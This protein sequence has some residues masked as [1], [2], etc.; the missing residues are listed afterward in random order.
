MPYDSPEKNRA[1]MAAALREKA[2]P[3]EAEE[4]GEGEDAPKCE[5]CG[6]RC[7]YCAGEM[8]RPGER[9]ETEARSPEEME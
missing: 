8:E 9:S 2:P 1:M 5:R 3:M 7:P 4:R 6:E